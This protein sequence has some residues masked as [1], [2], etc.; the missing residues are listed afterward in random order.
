MTH[1]RPQM[2][3]G[4]DHPITLERARPTLSSAAAR[5]SSPRP[6][7]PSRCGRLLTNQC[8]TSRSTMLTGTSFG[9]AIITAIAPTRARRLTTT[10]SATTGTD[11]SA[12]VWYYDD[13]FP[14]VADIKGHVA[15]YA[16]RVDVKAT[17]TPSSRRS[18]R[19]ANS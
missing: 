10:S 17:P 4:P 18:I 6:T 13:P 14:A 9:S 8:S 7:G 19:Q 15:F 2:T 3:P 1:P 5:A 16:D 11:L 12:V